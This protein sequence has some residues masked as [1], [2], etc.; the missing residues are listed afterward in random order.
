MKKLTPI[1]I[2]AAILFLSLPVH[3][4]TEGSSNQSVL[5][6]GMKLM[7]SLN[8]ST[9][10]DVQLETLSD[11]V[12]YVWFKNGMRG[13]KVTLTSEAMETSKTQLNYIFGMVGM[14]PQKFSNT[15]SIFC[16]RI[17]LMELVNNNET[18]IRLYGPDTDPV[19]LV[20]EGIQKRTYKTA[21]GEAEWDVV[22]ARGENGEYMEVLFD[23]MFPLITKLQLDFTIE[24][25]NIE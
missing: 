10:F 1:G 20:S 8:E 22:A 13:F 18:E 6:T 12:E 2:L 3:A 9:A 15:T 21:D 17:N 25:K 7:Y 5:K 23:G 16:S 24:L 4:Q 19:K 11:A 14:P